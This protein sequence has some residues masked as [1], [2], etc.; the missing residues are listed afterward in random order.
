MS[1]K[2]TGKIQNKAKFE[3]ALKRVDVATKAC[4]NELIF[5]AVLNVHRT[6]LKLLAK[7]SFGKEQVRYTGGE[8]RTVSVSKPGDAPNTDTSHGIKS[9]RF[10]VDADKMQGAVGTDLDYMAILEK[11]S[12]WIEARPWRGPARALFR[13]SGWGPIFKAVGPKAFRQNLGG[14]A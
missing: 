6:A 3:R 1:F 11:K 12:K 2:L 4:A 5:E 8:A 10:E 9:V 7:R 14:P 13:K